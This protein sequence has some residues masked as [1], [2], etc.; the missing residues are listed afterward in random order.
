MDAEDK[1]GRT[2]LFAAVHNGRTDT[3][4]R[5]LK[6]GADVNHADKEGETAL[7][8]AIELEFPAIAK[9]L[10]KHGADVNHKNTIGFPVLSFLVF[11]LYIQSLAKRLELIQLLLE[12][13]ASV[14]M[15]A[16]ATFKVIC[17]RSL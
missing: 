11:D 17:V 15:K 2:R 7:F 12:H 8:L 10:L 5:L 16:S 13:G 3:V 1:D 14:L 4:K 6:S 9:L